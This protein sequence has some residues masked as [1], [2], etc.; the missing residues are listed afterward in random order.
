MNTIT[1]YPTAF[2][3]DIQLQQ[4]FSNIINNYDFDIIIETGTHKGETTEFLCSFQKHVISTEIVPEFHNTV[5]EK[6]KNLVNLTL[7]LGDSATSLE[8]IF[9]AIKDKKIIAFLDSHCFNDTVLER[10]LELFT[11][12]THKPTLII[13][14][15]YVP[16][17]SLGYDSWDGHRYDIDFYKKYFDRLYG[18][19]EYSYS[20][21]DDS[22]T[23]ARRGIILIQPK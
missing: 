15:F 17:T 23:G 13:H 11:Q 6:L 9:F 7:L 3:G 20:Y 8:S 16:G 1:Q 18:H 4:L 5:K 19:D 22:A 10:E 12:L 14:D 2:N 21:N